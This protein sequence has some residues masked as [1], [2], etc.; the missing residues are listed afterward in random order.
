MNECLQLH[1]KHNYVV[2]AVVQGKNSLSVTFPK[3]NYLELPSQSTFYQILPKQFILSRINGK[4]KEYKFDA[5]SYALR[6]LL[7]ADI[8]VN[9]DKYDI[10]TSLIVIYDKDRQRLTPDN[11]IM[12]LITPEYKDGDIG[13]E[14]QEMA[15]IGVLTQIVLGEFNNIKQDVKKFDI[16]EGVEVLFNL[17]QGD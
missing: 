5:P 7:M 2:E 10:D 12:D 1:I 11:G 4:G 3:N 6:V 17:L 8:L 16:E 9:L 14:K 13:S 15:L